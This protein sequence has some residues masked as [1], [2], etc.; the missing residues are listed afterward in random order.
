MSDAQTRPDPLGGDR[1]SVRHGDCAAVLATL[2]AESVS[3][4][5]CDPPYGLSDHARHVPEIVAAWLSDGSASAVA[6]RLRGFMGRAWDALPPSPAQWREVCRVLKPGAYVLAFGGTRT[7]WLVKL[8]LALAGFEIRDAIDVCGLV[9]AAHLSWY[10]GQGFPKSLDVSKAI[11][12]AAGADREVIGH[13]GNPTPQ[14]IDRNALDYGGATGKA[15][16]GLKDGHDL[17]APA[18]PEAAAWEGWGTAL[19]PSVEPAVLARKP[20]CWTVAANVL[21]HGTGAL[22]IDGCRVPTT[23]GD[24]DLM[25]SRSHPHGTKGGNNGGAV[26]MRFDKPEGFNPSALGRW[27]SNLLLVHSP[28]CTPDRC[29]DG[30][31]VRAIGEQSGGGRGAAAPASGP[32]FSGPNGSVAHGPRAGMGDRPAKFHA[33]TDADATAARFYPQA[34]YTAEDWPFR[35]VPKASRA[36]RERGCERLPARSGADACDRDEGSAGLQS[37][38]AGAGRTARLVRC[39]HPTVKPAAV[40]AWLCRLCCPPGGVVLDPWT[41]SGSTGIGALR[42]GFR[43]LGI[44]RE[45]EYVA[46][47]RARIAATAA[48]PL[49][50]RPDRSGERARQPDLFAT[51][52]R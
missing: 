44:E 27:P 42:E 21:E 16:N 50:W 13:V 38:R 52:E 15:K 41:G 35:Y 29:A 3:A 9:S 32:Q 51:E 36:E 48:R 43:F 40:M 7:D 19:A 31:P 20:L 26:L 46:I 45:A 49:G 34:R 47:A 28:A 4:C 5:V 33:D 30:C 17:T 25:V 24:R 22:N 12:E 8:G 39:T 11:D 2:P 10:Q 23:Q 1:W 6:A 18:T 14:V 37:P